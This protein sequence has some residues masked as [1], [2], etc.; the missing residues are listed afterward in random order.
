MTKLVVPNVEVV[1]WPG[2]VATGKAA[3]AMSAGAVVFSTDAVTFTLATTGVKDLKGVVLRTATKDSY[4]ANDAIPVLLFGV[5]VVT[6]DAAVAEGA[7]LEAS[8]VS[9]AGQARAL[10]EG[11]FV[12]GVVK[13]AMEAKLGT[14]LTTGG[15]NAKALA[16]IGN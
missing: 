6:V 9:A 3:T 15:T 14:A 10:V 4:A 8:S 12:A 7:A 13:A 2:F 16:L 11:A 5:G 1:V